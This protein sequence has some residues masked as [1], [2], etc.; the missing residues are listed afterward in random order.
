MHIEIDPA[1]ILPIYRDDLSDYSHRYQIFMGGAGSGKSFYVAQKLIIKALFFKRR[2]L[3]VR[4]VGTTIRDSVWDQFTSTLSKWNLLPYCTVNVSIFKI[5]LPHG[6]EIIFKSMD[7]SEKIKSINNI[8]DIF[9]EEASE[10]DAEEV[11]QLDLRLR[12][13]ADNLQMYLAY[14][15]VSKANWTY[16]RYHSPEAIIQDNTKIITS[17]YKD[18]P[19]LSKEYIDSLEALINT[20]RN[21]YNVYVLGQYCSLDKLIYTNYTIKDFD[22]RQI[23]GTNIVGLDWGFTNDATTLIQSIAI[24]DT[25]YIYSEHYQTGMLNNDI[26]KLL[27]YKGLA[28]SLIIADSAEPK[29]IEE[30]KREGIPL[31]KPALKGPDSVRAGIQKLQQ[32]KLVVHPSCTNTII[33]LENYSYKKDKNTNEYTNEPIDKY[34]HCLDALRYSIQILGTDRKLKTMSKTAWGF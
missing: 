14:N 17:T 21:Y 2:I 29:S 4:K 3:V 11:T 6:S 30:V 7:D 18:N 8:T 28:K 16:I 27:K 9:I 12:G 26:A 25:I 33:E 5:T 24:E 34:N 22:Y 32:Y 20:N 13:Q 23:N 10:L 19:Y 1:I 15:P 31:I